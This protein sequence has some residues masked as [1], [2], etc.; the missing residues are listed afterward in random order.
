MPASCS[1]RSSLHQWK[2]STLLAPDSKPTHLAVSTKRKLIPVLAASPWRGPHRKLSTKIRFWG[3]NSNMNRYCRYTTFSLGLRPHL[4]GLKAREP[5][6]PSRNVHMF[7]MP[8]MIQDHQF[9]QVSSCH[10]GGSP[11]MLQVQDWRKRHYRWIHIHSWHIIHHYQ[12]NLLRRRSSVL[13]L[14]HWHVIFSRQS[15]ISYK[16]VRLDCIAVTT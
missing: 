6:Q 12:W 9:P 4:P 7:G 8:T 11:Y 3:F 10:D 13:H 5:S 14:S 1:L 16:L 15:P 2:E